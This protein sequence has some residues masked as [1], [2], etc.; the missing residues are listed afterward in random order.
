VSN[1]V[2]SDSTRKLLRPFQRRF[3]V[4]LF[5]GVAVYLIEAGIAEL[6][7]AEDARCIEAALR[8]RFGPAPRLVCYSEFTVIL[9]S[10]FSYGLGTFILSSSSSVLGIMLAAMLYGVLGGF[11]AQLPQRWAIASF[12]VVNLLLVFVITSIQYLSTYIR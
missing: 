7:L 11:V 3:L 9:L 1:P 8:M 10:T 5:L 6:L 12:F 4:G 2:I